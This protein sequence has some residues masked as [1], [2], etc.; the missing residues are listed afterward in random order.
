M[1]KT[2]LVILAA[3]IGSRFGEGIKQLT[4][5]GKGGELII[6][7]SIHDAIEAGFNKVVFLIRKDLE[8][9]FRE[10][11]GDR[12]SKKIEVE[13]A[14]Q[15]IDDLPEGFACPETRKKPWG[16]GQALLCC[17]DVVHEPFIVINADDYYGK[18]AFKA[19][20]AYLEQMISGKKLDVCMTG[21]VLKNTL[22]ENG[23]VTR[24]ICS[25]SPEGYLRR[26]TETYDIRREGKKIKAQ[27]RDIS[28]ESTVS[29]NFWGFTPDVFPVLED[30]FR[31][32]LEIN[33]NES[34]KEH[35]L[36]TIVDELIRENKASVSVLMSTD[37]WFGI[38]YRADV[39]A[40]KKAIQD[41]VD[42]GVYPETLY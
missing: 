14:F 10:L 12:V 38:T 5:F 28:P 40:V 24:G 13:Y 22:S 18:E 7:Y 20:H 8:A 27:E 26:V 15:E 16:T 17:R 35:L 19:S 21:F 39:P 37:T 34:Y 2:T 41:L 4:R 3:G 30:K 1:K 42:R 31:E 33:I 11:I 29:M 6:D 23:G 9:D 36:P 32:F 25:I